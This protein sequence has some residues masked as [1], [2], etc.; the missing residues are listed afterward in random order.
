MF[1]QGST[2]LI[3]HEHERHKV[4]PMYHESKQSWQQ[5]ALD[6][7]TI[8]LNIENTELWSIAQH[9]KGRQQD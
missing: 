7:Q 1:N 9:S 3:E 6:L 5:T 2:I 8:R 4:G